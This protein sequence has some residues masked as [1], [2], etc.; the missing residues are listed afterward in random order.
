MHRCEH[1]HTQGVQTT[2]NILTYTTRM[3]CIL[4][5]Q[6]IYEMQKYINAHTHGYVVNIIL[7]MHIELQLKNKRDEIMNWLCGLHKYV[8]DNTMIGKR[9]FVVLCICSY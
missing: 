7:Y 8:S 2:Q 9:L 5:T 3:L 6:T 1:V 4:T